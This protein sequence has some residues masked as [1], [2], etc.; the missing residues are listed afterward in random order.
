MVT[1]VIV[2]WNAGLQLLD[3]VLSIQKHHQDQISSVVVVDNKSNDDSLANIEGLTDLAFNLEIIRNFENR[4]FAVACNQGAALTESEFLLFLN[5]DTLLF[6]DSISSAI[7]FMQQSVNSSIG[8]VGIQLCDDENNIWRSCSRFPS[9]K[10]FIAHSIGLD[11]I[12]PRL[13]NFMMEWDHATTRQVDH[14]IGAFFLVRRSL[15]EAL[16]GFDSRFFV[17]LEDLDF[18]KRAMALGWSSTYFAESRAYHAG[19]G[20]SRQ[21]KARRLFYSLRSRILYSFKH[22]HP[23][24][25]FL[26]LIMVLLIEPLSRTALA[27]AKRSLASVNE[28]WSAYFMLYQ[29]LPELLRNKEGD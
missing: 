15:F 9:A 25:A 13:G 19:G 29:W 4:G 6:E 3:T 11:R 22:F 23:W 18:S 24:G 10:G 27:L 17:Y 7:S 28:T 2:N 21:V 20:T 26:V 1:I 12:F 16:K 8:I 14:V 5:P